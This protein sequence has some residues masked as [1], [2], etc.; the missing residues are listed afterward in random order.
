MEEQEQKEVADSEEEASSKNKIQAA[1]EQLVYEKEAEKTQKEE[2]AIF[3]EKQTR[4]CPSFAS[5]GF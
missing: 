5:L 3:G 2:M 1:E 4:N